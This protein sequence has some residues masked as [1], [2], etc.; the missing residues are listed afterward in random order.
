MCVCVL[1]CVCGEAEFVSLCVIV[2]GCV[3]IHRIESFN[4]LNVC[5]V[6]ETV[7]RDLCDL[8]DDQF[9]KLADELRD[10]MLNVC[11]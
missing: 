4:V 1:V 10:Q 9:Q 6:Q 7:K 8:N 2:L 5:V 3:Y 11:T